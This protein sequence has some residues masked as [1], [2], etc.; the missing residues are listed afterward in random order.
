MCV[1]VR[2][3]CIVKNHASLW[4]IVCDL[5]CGFCSRF[6][7]DSLYLSEETWRMI[8]I[9]EGPLG[10]GRSRSLSLSLSLSPHTHVITYSQ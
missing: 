5:V 10:F 6:P 7:E 8:R 1:R 3:L 9:G 4:I 2:A